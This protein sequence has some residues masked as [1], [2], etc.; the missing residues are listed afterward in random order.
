MLVWS[1]NLSIAFAEISFHWGPKS[2]PYALKTCTIKFYEES[3]SQSIASICQS[4]SFNYIWL[5]CFHLHPPMRRLL[6]ISRKSLPTLITILLNWHHEFHL[7]IRLFGL[8]NIDYNRYNAL[9]CCFYH[10]WIKLFSCLQYLCVWAN[11]YP[12]YWIAPHSSTWNLVTN[13]MK[14]SI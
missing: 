4:P 3:I 8:F 13:C 5:P 14:K 9:D 6:V 11:P 1:P 12:T 10:V 2:C 7:I